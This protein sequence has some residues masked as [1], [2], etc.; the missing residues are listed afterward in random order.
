MCL[1][2]ASQ[3]DRLHQRWQRRAGQKLGPKLLELGA[4]TTE[5]LVQAKDTVM[6]SVKSTTVT[7]P[8]ISRH[9]RVKLTP[10]VDQLMVE[11]VDGGVLLPKGAGELQSGDIE[12]V[13]ARLIE[14]LRTLPHRLSGR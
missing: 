10:H 5:K 3:G 11:G 8:T 1:L 7:R 14:S 4:Q 12:G 13:A 6:L 9:Q 2:S